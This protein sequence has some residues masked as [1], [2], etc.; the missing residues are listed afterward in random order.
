MGGAIR[1]I[2][3]FGWEDKISKRIDGKRAD[4]LNLLRKQRLL[5]LA[6]V[7]VT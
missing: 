2:K 4:E 7:L 5:I 3:L 1:M 6:N